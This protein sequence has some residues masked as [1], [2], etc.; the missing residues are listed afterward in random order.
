MK[1]IFILSVIF[2]LIYSP[3]VLAGCDTPGMVFDTVQNRCIFTN[4]VIQ[5]RQQTRDCNQEPTQAAQQTCY[6]NNACGEGQEDSP[7]CQAI[8]ACQSSSDVSERL[9]CMKNESMADNKAFATKGGWSITTATIAMG[10]GLTTFLTALP[11]NSAC[12]APSA[13][14][15]LAASLVIGLAEVGTYIAYRSKMKKLYENYEE[16]VTSRNI[17]SQDET[18][19]T[20]EGASEEEHPASAQTRALQL[21]VDQEKAYQK[22][23]K[24]KKIAYATGTALFMGAAVMATIEALQLKAAT[25]NAT[26]AQLEKLFLCKSS[27]KK[28]E[29]NMKNAQ[30]QNKVAGALNDND[31]KKGKTSALSVILPMTMGLVPMMIPL[32][33]KKK[34]ASLDSKPLTKE[35]FADQYLA[36]QEQLSFQ[37][38]EE[39]IYSPEQHQ[40]VM[41]LGKT[42]DEI[43]EEE[44]AVLAQALSTV[45]QIIASP[46]YPLIIEG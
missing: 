39:F 12:K 26:K 19:I 41:E 38:G 45:Q 17:A 32:F 15:I 8:S 24:A 29:E 16:G 34:S 27:V 5:A 30:D 11:K 1:Q 25:D 6:F 14:M 13:Y 46:L 35:A 20:E 2:Q 21:L 31:G 37:T 9:E 18:T 44:R 4:E 40:Q 23:L 7:Q 10:V 36:I 22:I 3:S 42:L 33:T 43:P 28:H